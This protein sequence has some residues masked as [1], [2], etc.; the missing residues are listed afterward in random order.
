MSLKERLINLKNKLLRKK[1]IEQPKPKYNIEESNKKQLERKNQQCDSLIEQLE[2][3]EQ[4]VYTTE[5]NEQITISEET[6]EHFLTVLREYRK[7]DFIRYTIFTEETEYASFKYYLDSDEKG[8]SLTSRTY[9]HPIAAASHK[10]Y[11]NPAEMLH[12]FSL[13][14]VNTKSDSKG[15]SKK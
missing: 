1:E 14:D 5:D 4:L 9:D 7:E 11:Y 15:S 13:L 12:R 10:H 6:K 3:S 8:I 2:N